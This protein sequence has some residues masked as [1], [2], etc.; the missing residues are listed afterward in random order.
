MVDPKI[1][2]NNEI[3]FK[4]LKDHSRCLR[5]GRLVHGVVHNLNGSVQILSM[6]MEMMRKLMDKK[7][8]RSHAFILEKMEQCASQIEHLRGILTGLETEPFDAERGTSQKI[9]LH[10][11]IERALDFFRHN[12]FFKH[13][14]KVNKNFTSRLPSLRGDETD[15]HEGL[16]NLIE[17]AIEAMEETPR[18]E[19][20]LI[21][22]AS[23]EHIQLIIQDTGCG[24]PDHL[25]GYL[26]TPFFTTKNGNH[27]GIG[28]YMTRQLLTPYGAI[29]EPFSRQGETLFSVKVPR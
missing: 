18:K 16:L 4:M 23:H 13:Q 2:G 28:L 17:N 22:R 14:V 21:T 20:T 24:V 1:L 27:Y 12:L 6:Q 26:F 25:R 15:F 5:I 29:V 19:L 9:Q 8:D 10:E 7:D 3:L 11:L